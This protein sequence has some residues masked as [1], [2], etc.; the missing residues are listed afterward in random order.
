MTCIAAI[1]H[2]DIIVMG[3]DTVASDEH[4]MYSRSTP[5]IFRNRPFLIGSAGSA[6][7][8]QLLQYS[9]LV[10]AQAIDQDDMDYMVNTFAESFRQVLLA[11]GAMYKT[12][13]VEFYHG[14][15]MVV[16]NN[17]IYIVD[18]ALHVMH[19]AYPYAS[20]GSGAQ[21]AC[22]AL[23]ALMSIVKSGKLAPK[24]AIGQALAAAEEHA[25]GVRRPFDY[26]STAEEDET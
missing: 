19:L 10:P 21:V 26:F 4:G 14:E 23:H 16:Y 12:D 3:A 17:E 25:V 1:K 22:G 18:G 7:I 8:G 24:D 9:L 13:E 2:D 15:T 20:V 6:R 5:K 11:R